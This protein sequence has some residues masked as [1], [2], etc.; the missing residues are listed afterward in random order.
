MYYLRQVGEPCAT[1]EDAEDCL[2]GALS[3]PNIVFGFVDQQNRPVFFAQYLEPPG[4][5]PGQLL[6]KGVLGER[7]TCNHATK[8]SMV[9]VQRWSDAHRMTVLSYMNTRSRWYLFGHNH[10]TD[11]GLSIMYLNAEHDVAGLSQGHITFDL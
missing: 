5:A 1:V 11:P 2:A 10:P 4:Q 3:I 9:T 7:S 8:V 6:L